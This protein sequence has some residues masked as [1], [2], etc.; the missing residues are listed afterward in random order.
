MLQPFTG[1]V[2]IQNVAQ[3][4]AKQSKPT[5]GLVA[6]SNFPRHAEY[7]KGARDAG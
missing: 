6:P 4:L 5:D 7:S 2:A 1:F 3:S